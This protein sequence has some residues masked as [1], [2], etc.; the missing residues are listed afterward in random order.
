MTRME[1]EHGGL[2]FRR[3][4][5]AACESPVPVV[6][7]HPGKPVPIEADSDRH[8]DRYRRR[9][10]VLYPSHTG[11]EEIG[12]H[13]SLRRNDQIPLAR[14]GRSPWGGTYVELTVHPVAVL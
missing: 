4:R 8:H 11:G 13:S 7:E 14:D 10:F 9:R 1:R 3:R 12:R 6:A 2:G 5:R